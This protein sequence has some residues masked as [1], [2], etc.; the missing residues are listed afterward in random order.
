ML[1]ELS[2]KSHRRGNGTVFSLKYTINLCGALFVFAA[3]S[4]GKSCVVLFLFPDE[5]ISLERD[6]TV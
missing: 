6:R 3:A 4:C 1:T 2:S 5:V